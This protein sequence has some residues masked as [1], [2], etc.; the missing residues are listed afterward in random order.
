MKPEIIPVWFD[1]CACF[2]K[3]KCIFSQP[4]VLS[5]RQ[6][7]DVSC[8]IPYCPPVAVQREGELERPLTQTLHLQASTLA[9]WLALSAAEVAQPWQ[10][11]P[12]LTGCNV[13]R[14]LG[15][16]HQSTNPEGFF[17]FSLLLSF[18]LSVSAPGEDWGRHTATPAE[19]G[20]R[21]GSSFT[22]DRLIEAAWQRKSIAKCLSALLSCFFLTKT[23]KNTIHKSSAWFIPIQLI[24]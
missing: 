24:Y 6:H 22:P 1:S 3:M 10:W 14:D 13:C 15:F 16:L 17:F 19:G 7:S 4:C 5:H 9:Y 23:F 21:P 18:C 8:W 12:E 2:F 20:R 11:I